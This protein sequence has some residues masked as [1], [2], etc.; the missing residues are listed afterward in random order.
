M[1]YA[2]RPRRLVEA[3]QGRATVAT[4]HAEGIGPE[5][6][7]LDFEPTG[8][9]GRRQQQHRQVG[10]VSE[11]H[12]AVRHALDL[13]VALGQMLPLRA[14]GGKPRKLK[15]GPIPTPGLADTVAQVLGCE[16]DKAMQCSAWSERPLSEE[17][18]QYAAKDAA[19]LHELY[20][21]VCAA[22][23]LRAGLVAHTTH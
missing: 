3:M 14:S 10:R 8:K 6:G 4:I 7:D 5:G 17:Q 21:R 20:E 19:V 22:P 11:H 23:Q 1:V 18:L 16:L 2:V 13:Q 9:G 15:D 12:S